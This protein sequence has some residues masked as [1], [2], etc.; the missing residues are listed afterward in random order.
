M[1][2]KKILVVEDNPEIRQLLE[3]IFQKAGADVHLAVD[4]S[5][6]IRKFFL[7]KPALVFLD[8]MM[9]EMDGFEACKRIRQVSN[10]PVI[11]LTSLNSDDEIIHGLESGADDFITKPFSANVL[12][13]R[14]KALLR[15]LEL[16]SETKA[17]LLYSDDYLSIDLEKRVVEVEGEPIK[18]T[19]TE[20]NLLAYLVQNVGWIRTFEQILETVWGPEYQG[21]IDYIHVYISNLRRKIEVDPKNPQYLVS[22]HGVGYRF[23]AKT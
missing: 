1:I 6:G 11:M 21:S 13:A 14:A 12:V 7:E 10:V 5:A 19:R 20:Y 2:G 23:N 22:E 15:R 3:N 4:G 16:P 18:L 9:P 8:V 17:G